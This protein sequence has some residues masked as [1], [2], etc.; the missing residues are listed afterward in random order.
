MAP[1]KAPPLLTELEHPT[2]RPRPP[3][4]TPT[5]P[6]AITSPLGQYWPQPGRDLIVLDGIHALMTTRTMRALKDCTGARPAQPFTGQMWRANFRGKW[7][8]MW[9]EPHVL[10]PERF[11][12]QW[13]ELLVVE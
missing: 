2:K 9:Y 7:W 13:R 12:V 11:D 3:A 5:H 4:A 10:E 6:P 8:L 1:A